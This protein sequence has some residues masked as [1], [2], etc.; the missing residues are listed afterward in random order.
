MADPTPKEIR[1]GRGI[2]VCP[3][4]GYADGFHTAY[5]EPDEDGTH[6]IMLICPSCHAR[7]L[8]DKRL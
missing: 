6:R 5:V 2:V 3:A 7:Y 1:I 8:T 4:C